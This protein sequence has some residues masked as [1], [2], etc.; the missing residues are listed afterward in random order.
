MII[1]ILLLFPVPPVAGETFRGFHFLDNKVSQ[2]ISEGKNLCV[3]FP[4]YD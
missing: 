2:R 1:P 3:G 4:D